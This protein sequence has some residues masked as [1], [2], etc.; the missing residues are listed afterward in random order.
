MIFAYF[1][2]NKAEGLISKRAFQENKACQIFRKTNFFYPTRIMLCLLKTPIL[3]FA[4]LLYYQQFP[5]KTRKPHSFYTKEQFLRFKAILTTV[6]TLQ[7]FREKY[8]NLQHLQ[9]LRMVSE[10]KNVHLC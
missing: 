8:C 3:R 2:G 9:S 5:S 4:L 1:V 7:I 10:F 6:L